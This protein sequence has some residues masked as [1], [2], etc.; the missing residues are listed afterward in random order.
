MTRT[1]TSTE[2]RLAEAKKLANEFRAQ[3]LVTK[4]L[5]SNLQT[6]PRLCRETMPG[7]R[8]V[9]AIRGSGWWTLYSHPHC[10]VTD[11]IGVA[12]WTGNWLW[13]YGV[14]VPARASKIPPAPTGTKAAQFRR[15]VRARLHTP[16][17]TLPVWHWCVDPEETRIGVSDDDVDGLKATISIP[18]AIGQ[19][20]EILDT[21]APR[22]TL[23]IVIVAA[24][25]LVANQ[26]QGVR[27]APLPVC[28]VD[29]G[30]RFDRHDYW[31]VL[32]RRE[33]HDLEAAAHQ[34]IEQYA[35][36]FA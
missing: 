20:V 28:T 19:C 17:A 30:G 6:V 27:G 5:C 32:T 8:G 31:E 23:R 11:R 1:R 13:I 18:G 24:A 21:Q 9:R 36:R 7:C 15:A 26:S 14:S 29:L 4:R 12:N 35:E 33:Q 25:D 10:A 22:M 34:A 2:K 16:H 3:N